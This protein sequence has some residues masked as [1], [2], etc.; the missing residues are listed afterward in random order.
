MSRLDASADAARRESRTQHGI[1]WEIPWDECPE[2]V[3]AHWRAVVRAASAAGR[4]YDRT[5][6]VPLT[7][8]EETP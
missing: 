1:T 8:P 3:R 2:H 5:A 6:M 7:R 4:E